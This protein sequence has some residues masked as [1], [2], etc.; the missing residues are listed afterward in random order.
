[1]ERFV[2]DGYEPLEK[3]VLL[4]AQARSPSLW[5]GLHRVEDELY[6]RLGRS[7]HAEALHGLLVRALRDAAASAC[8]VASAQKRI[9]SYFD[10]QGVLR[11]ALEKPLLASVLQVDAT[12]GTNVFGGKGMG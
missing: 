5:D 6:Q 3:A 12:G 10:T 8:A 2:P 1:M 11:V 4:V 7:I 9:T